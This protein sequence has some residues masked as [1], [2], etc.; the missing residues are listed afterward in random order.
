MMI[1]CGISIPGRGMHQRTEWGPNDRAR[2]EEFYASLRGYTKLFFDLLMDHP[3]EGIDADQI[4]AYFAQHS[5]KGNNVPNRLSVAA[6]LTPVS[7]RCR[8]SGLPVPYDR[9]AGANGAASVYAIKPTVARLFRDARMKIDPSYSEKTRRTGWSDADVRATIADYLE[10]LAEE[11]S[12][13]HYSKAAHRRKLRQQLNAA[14]TD[15]AIEFEYQNISAAMLDL[16]LPYIRGYKPRS[17]YQAALTAE[18][19]RRLEADPQLLRTLKAGTDGG[20]SPGSHLQRTPAPAPS[21]TTAASPA[22]GSRKGRHLD[23]GLL[24]EE[25]RHRGAHG[26]ELVADYERAWLRQHGRHDLAGRVQWTARDNGDGLGYDVLSFD[27]DGQHRYIEVKTTALGAET[28]FYITSAELDFAQR[29]LDRYALYRVYD[30]LG[31]PRFFG[32]EGDIVDVLV[33]TPATYSAR[34]GACG[35]P[36]RGIGC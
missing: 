2:A 16:G 11:A 21:A 35:V 13:R 24:Q 10:M 29:H 19:Q 18:I 36:K 25:N 20:A 28:P 27:L 17:N 32:L 8:S 5:P 7:R 12:G 22:T 33:L 3:G 30:V 9:W 14:R 34:I 26:E 15:S 1:H 6:S 4:T 23:Y 31:E